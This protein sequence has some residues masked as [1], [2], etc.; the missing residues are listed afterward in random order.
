MQDAAARRNSWRQA[1]ANSPWPPAPARPARCGLRAQSTAAG[2]PAT[3][4]LAHRSRA[5][6]AKKQHTREERRAHSSMVSSRA[7]Q[8][9]IERTR[10][11]ECMRA[12]PPPACL[13]Q[14]QCREDAIGQPKAR[15]V[16]PKH[17]AVQP[18]LGGSQD[19]AIAV[20]A[21]AARLLQAGHGCT[22]RASGSPAVCACW[23]CVL[24]SRTTRVV[25]ACAA[26]DALGQLLL[27]LQARCMAKPLHGLLHTPPAAC[28]RA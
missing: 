10:A 16:G 7:A 24:R 28:G 19:E 12:A 6:C 8:C 15:D 13:E 4:A 27:L 26:V 20:A 5:A 17:A 1:Q 3:T 25:D 22:L 14:Q 2:R 23:L 11:R 21:C 18:Q 9:G